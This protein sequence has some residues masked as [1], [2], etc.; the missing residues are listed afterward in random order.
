MDIALDIS[1]DYKTDG[2]GCPYMIYGTDELLQQAYI[3]LSSLRGGFYYDRELGLSPADRSGSAA[4]MA[5]ARKAL[6]ELPQAEVTGASVTSA[7]AQVTLLLGGEQH[8][9]TLRGNT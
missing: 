8:T 3:L 2:S 1:G 4:L 5:A 9:I 6:R 7:A